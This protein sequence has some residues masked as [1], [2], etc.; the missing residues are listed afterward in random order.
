[1]NDAWV[2]RDRRRVWHGFTQMASYAGNA[3]V[4][5]ERAEGRWLSTRDGLD[6]TTTLGE[7][8]EAVRP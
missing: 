8:L 1:M 6:V 2:E 4:V 7:L 5:V 3:P